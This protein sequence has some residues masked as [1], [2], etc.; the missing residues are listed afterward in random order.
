LVQSSERL[1]QHFEKSLATSF[2]Q[3]FLR[4]TRPSSKRLPEFYVRLGEDSRGSRPTMAHE[5]DGSEAT[6]MEI[7][8]PN[9]RHSTFWF[10]FVAAFRQEQSEKHSLQHASLPVFH[11]ITGELVPL[12]RA[13]WDHLAASSENSAH[14]QPHWHFVQRPERIE[15]VVLSL[16]KSSTGTVQEFAPTEDSEFF[17]GLVDCGRFHFAMTSMWEKSDEPA[18][19]KRLFETEDFLH[20]FDSLTEYIAGQIAYL[21]SLMPAGFGATDLT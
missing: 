14:A 13:E 3:P 10:G 15:R 17:R 18:Y 1:I 2:R 7:M 21:A 16:M 9:D 4:L 20:W 11:E 12:F 8:L 19:R 5:D 6:V